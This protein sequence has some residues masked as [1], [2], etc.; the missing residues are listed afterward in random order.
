M[1]T[2]DDDDADR[3]K[4]LEEKGY[5][6]P[7]Y[8]FTIE[9]D[10]EKSTESRQLDVMGWIRTKFTDKRTRKPLANKKYTVYLLDGST[11]K[12]STDENGFVD[13][14]ELKYGEY[15]IDFED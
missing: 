7:E 4:E 5:T 8:A 12:D 14:K 9:C 13:L 10:E 3:K 2:A 15:F 1:Y 6:L 11:I